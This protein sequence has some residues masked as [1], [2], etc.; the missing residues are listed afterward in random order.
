MIYNDGLLCVFHSDT[1]EGCSAPS[2][3]TYVSTSNMVSLSSSLPRS[4][5]GLS[6]HI[7]GSFS[8]PE[9]ETLETKTVQD[10]GHNTSLILSV[11]CS[12]VVYFFQR[13]GRGEGAHSFLCILVVVILSVCEGQIQSFVF[14]VILTF[15]T[16]SPRVW[17]DYPNTFKSNAPLY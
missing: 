1:K 17:T 14:C 3:P 13:V 7:K 12:G 2:S 6:S 4:M 11:L 8:S 16:S 10:S 5:G 15:W 9:V